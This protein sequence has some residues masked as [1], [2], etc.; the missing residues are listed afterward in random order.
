M[1]IHWD[2]IITGLVS[3]GILWAV[4]TMSKGLRAY[5][6]ES[7]QWR[8]DMD[9]KVDAIRDATQTTM[10]TSLLHYIEKYQTRGWLTPEERASLY[11]MHEKYTAL[12]ANGYIDAYMRRIAALPDREI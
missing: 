11:D 8:T 4:R 10:R 3:A 2:T 12:E 7:K 1:A 9:E 6:T 5:S